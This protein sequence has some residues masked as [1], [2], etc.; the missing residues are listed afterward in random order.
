MRSRIMIA[1]HLGAAPEEGNKVKS[2]TRMCKLR[3]A[4]KPRRKDGETNW[5]NVTAFGYNAEYA[6]NYLGKGDSVLIEGDVDLRK[7]T[8]RD[9][10]KRVSVDVTAS[11]IQGLGKRQGQQ[12]D[13]GMAQTDEPIPF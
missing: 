6:L 2:G 8:D 10:N 1:G 7:Y 3:I 11:H 4:S 9:G 13:R 12:E 5:W